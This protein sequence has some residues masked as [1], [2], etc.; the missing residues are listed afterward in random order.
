MF[1][2]VQSINISIIS[3][4][5]LAKE[6]NNPKIIFDC[7]YDQ[8]MNKTA[9]RS[10]ARQIVRSFSENRKN[11]LPFD[12]YL[13][14][15]NSEHIMMHELNSL[16]INLVKA[17]LEIHSE[18]F[19]KVHPKE[20]F[21]YLT[22]YSKNLLQIEDLCDTLVVGG[23][24]DKGFYGPITQAK[25][26]ELN[27]R[28][29]WL[30]I[31]LKHYKGVGETTLPLDIITRILL[32]FKHSRDWNKAL[33]HLPPRL[34]NRANSQNSDPDFD[35]VHVCTDRIL[36]VSRGHKVHNPPT[37]NLKFDEISAKNVEKKK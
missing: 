3:R 37:N 28:T 11:V 8:F 1:R 15:A 12:L 17:P 18:C 33:E 34:V 20:S 5:W 36:P 25:A 23:V 35:A 26:K 27:I 13:C 29:A 6:L 7:S 2:T 14:S 4:L 19:S 22:P 32:E 16:M 31:N 30:P 9:L 24:I 10:L 21:V